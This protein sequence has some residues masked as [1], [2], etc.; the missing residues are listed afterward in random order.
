ML[1]ALLSLLNGPTAFLTAFYYIAY[2]LTI[3]HLTHLKRFWV[4]K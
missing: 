4:Q 1:F 2:V 3:S